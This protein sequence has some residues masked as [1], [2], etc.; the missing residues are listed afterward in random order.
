MFFSDL[1]GLDLGASMDIGAW[2]RHKRRRQAVGEASVR[3]STFLV[4]KVTIQ[5]RT[6]KLQGGIMVTMGGIC[7]IHGLQ[8]KK[9]DDVFEN[10]TQKK[11]S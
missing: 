11:T 3:A 5:G 6:V 9:S 8:T 7:K 4:G 1:S 10:Y 2:G